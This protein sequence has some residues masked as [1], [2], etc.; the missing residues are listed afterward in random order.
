MAAS[1]LPSRSLT[2]R[3]AD[4]DAIPGE[5]TSE[6]TKLFAERLQAWK[7]AV[8]YLE[9]YVTAT[10]KTNHAHG[11]EYERVLKAVKDPLK[12]GHHF[13]QSLGGVAGMFE[14]IR[15]NTQGISNQHY[16]TAKQLKGSILPIFDR[17]HTE[18][19]N[20]NKELTKGAGKG[21]KSVDKARAHTQK[22]IELLGQ[23]TATF[24]SHSGSMKATDDPYVLQRGVMHRLNKQ[25]Q[26]E[27]NNRQDLISVQNSFAQFEA[28]IL[29][30]VQ[31]GMAQFLQVVT[32]QA[33]H[34]K[35]AYGDMVGTSQRI[36]PDF[37]WNGFIKRNNSVL[38]DPSAPA[39]TISQIG[40]PNQNHRST[41]P[42]ISG[43]LE[44]KGKIMRSYDTNYYVVT[45]S[46]FLHEFKTDDDF[47]KDPVPE[48]SVYLPDC[49]I[50]AVNGNK[51]NVKGKDVSGGKIGGAF[52]MSHEMQFKAHTPQAAAQWWEIIRNAAGTVTNDLPESTPTSPVTAE[53]TQP[54]PLQT[55]DLQ[56]TGTV[57]DEHATPGSA[58][59][60]GSAVSPQGAAPTSAV[61]GEPGRY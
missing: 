24:E 43:S 28:H 40:F 58:V 30:T 4:E 21:S 33:E 17:L 23:H 31:H 52:S 47:A 10:E 29:Q 39:R 3:S 15:S 59:A 37:E 45:P 56:S 16:E 14:N 35:S 5:D 27:N 19:K 6:V 55:Q 42:L 44:R 50:G 11:K 36:P 18:I 34:T 57:A 26:E 38:I 48:L 25:I 13:D 61:P 9:D 2:N 12:E 46:K 49:M 22:H 7:H 20:K 41:Q 60:P 1:E 32:T 51:F 53:Q 8:A 54:A